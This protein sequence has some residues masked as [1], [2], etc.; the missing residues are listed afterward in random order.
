M[1][2]SQRVRRKHSHRNSG[3]TRHSS[4]SKP[5]P[6]TTARLN[7]RVHQPRLHL[8]QHILSPPGVEDL[9]RTPDITKGLCRLPVRKL[10]AQEPAR[11]SFS[12]SL[13]PMPDLRRHPILRLHVPHT[14]SSRLFRSLPTFP[15][16]LCL[17]SDQEVVLMEFMAHTTPLFASRAVAAPPRSTHH[18]LEDVCV[19]DTRRRKPEGVVFLPQTHFPRCSVVAGQLLASILN[20]H[21]KTES[22]RSEERR[23]EEG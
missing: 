2:H 20:W 22:G 19:R 15:M 13:L 7:R 18:S 21:G 1:H 12:T 5:L 17:C 9:N 23:W 10:P 4:L 3:P 8:H 6:A 16:P 11:L 14:Q